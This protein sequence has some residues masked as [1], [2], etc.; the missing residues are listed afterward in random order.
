MAPIEITPPA[1]VS[2]LPIVVLLLH[3]GASFALAATAKACCLANAY[4]GDVGDRARASIVLC[5][6]PAV[7]RRQV[8]A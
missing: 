6:L 1:F 2:L 4:E 5:A 7:E 3:A 8:D